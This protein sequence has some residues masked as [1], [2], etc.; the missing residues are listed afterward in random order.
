MFDFVILNKQPDTLIEEG[1]QYLA[2]FSAPSITSALA[3]FDE[4]VSMWNR[5]HFTLF[6]GDT[7]YDEVTQTYK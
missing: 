4:Y 3:I 2:Q 7:F 1:P 5:G 6:L